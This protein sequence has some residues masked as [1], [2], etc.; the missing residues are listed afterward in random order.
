M[1]PTSVS[2]SVT[3][4][5]RLVAKAP[6]G[7]E[8]TGKSPVDR[9][10]L[11]WKWSIATDE[12]GIPIGWVADDAN[13][14]DSVILPGTLDEV[15]DADCS[16]RSARCTST[17]V[18]TT[19]WSAA[20]H[21]ARHRRSRRAQVR[22]PSRARRSRPSRVPLGLRWPVE[23]T[24]SWLSNYGQL[25]RNTDCASSPWIR[26]SPR[27]DSHSPGAGPT[28]PCQQ[29]DPV[30][31]AGGERKSTSVAADPD[32]NAAASRA[33]QRTVLGEHATEAGSM[34]RVLLDPLV[35]GL[36]APPVGAGRRPRG[37]GLRPRPPAPVGLYE[38]G[39]PTG[40][41]E[42]KP[43]RRR[44]AP[45]TIFVTRTCTGESPGRR[46]RDGIFGTDTVK[47]PCWHHRVRSSASTR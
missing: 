1:T 40:G 5:R 12:V 28:R 30:V 29:E 22:P 26:P 42:R 11:G 41:D 6:C 13:H 32:A 45:R 15:D 38:R 27:S 43:G 20:R 7:G 4:G 21:R 16:T 18:M 35:A 39:G 24:N 25:R 10:K 3:W 9:G 34:Q 31:Q 17:G 37:G 2:F 46:I 19:A 36:D 14:N 47:S 44:R 8:G 33:G 23:R